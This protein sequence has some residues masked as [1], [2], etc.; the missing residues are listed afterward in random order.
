MSD[1]EGDGV[2]SDGFEGATAFVP[3]HVTGFFTV[4]LDDDP[5]RAGSRGGGIALSDGVRVTVR[6]APER[7]V[8]LD[9]TSLEMEAVERVL[10]AL[11]APLRVDAETPLPLGSGFGVSGAMALGTALAAART[12]ERSLSVDELVRMAHGAEA[13]SGTGLGD[14]VAQARGGVPIRLDPGAPPHGR[15]DAIASPA[16]RVEYVSFG[17]RSTAEVIDGETDLL[18][19]TGR[20][21]LST[22]VQ[23]PALPTL[24]HASR[25]FA[26][27]A[28]LL[29]PRVRE[30]VEDVSEADGEAFVAMPGETVVA[31]D[32]GLSDAGYDPEPCRIHTAG[33]T[34]ER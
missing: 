1:D 22:V 25:R 3:G 18:T 27:E 7:A 33:A 11:S 24:C 30:A 6:P 17:E 16:R 26:R 2:S 28:D 5:M 20:R 32:S 13:Q 14:V 4:E 23:D 9:G 21:A 29:T 8:Y 31:L 15:V 12:T 19:D 10:D 34:V